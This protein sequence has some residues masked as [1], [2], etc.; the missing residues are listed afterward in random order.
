MTS[1]VKLRRICFDTHKYMSDALKH[2]VMD[3]YL[4]GG[5]ID[6]VREQWH[7]EHV[8]PRQAG[9]SDDADNLKP[10][11]IECH[12]PKTAKETNIRAQVRRSADNHY[13]VRPRKRSWP[14]GKNTPFRKKIN[15]QVVRRDEG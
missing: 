8:L 9:G 12:K 3:C 13:G 10:A 11:H 4:C 1:S 14:C 7:C 6:P 15:G 5:Q 2:F